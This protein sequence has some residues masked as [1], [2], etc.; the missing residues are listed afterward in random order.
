M[1][2]KE[3]KV[4]KILSYDVI[5]EKRKEENSE[6]FKN[7]FDDDIFLIKKHKKTKPK[8]IKFFII[9][10]VAIIIEIG[11]IIFILIY[12]N[13]TTKISC[14]IGEEEKCKTCKEASNECLACNPGYFIP[15]DEEKIK[16]KCQKC[17]V[18]NC[19]FCNGTKLSNMCYSCKYYLEPLIRKDKIISCDYTC[20]T[21]EKEKCAACSEENICSSCNDDY[22]LFKGKCFLDYSFR[23]TYHTMN[24][25]TVKLIGHPDIYRIIKMKIGE[26][27]LMNLSSNYTFPSAGN[28][29]VDILIDISQITSFVNFFKSVTSLISIS[30]YP[31]FYNEN[32]KDMSG[33]FSGCSSLVSIDMSNFQS[34]NIINIDEMF[35]YC[36]KLPF[37]NM[38]TFNTEN[39]KS[40][41]GLFKSCNSLVSIDFS[42]INT[43]NLVDM[44]HIF[45]NCKSLIS[46]NLS[47]FNTEKVTNMNGLFANCQ[48]L[49]S[50]DLS[51]FDTKNVVD[52]SWMFSY[53]NSLKVLDLSF[54]NTEK[55]INLNKM[56]SHC[57]NLTFINISNFNTQNVESMEFMFY[58]CK[59]LKSINLSSFITKKVRNMYSMLSSCSSLTS[60][61]I[62]NFYINSSVDISNM[63]SH[64]S[65]LTFI[66]ISSFHRR[67]ANFNMLNDLPD[68]GKIYVSNDLYNYTNEIL[69]NWEI[70]IP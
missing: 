34:Q 37:F 17:P 60:I 27:R 13:K 61:N 21:G 19:S 36:R 48:S 5:I 44:E 47:N 14:A 15:E 16:Y 68:K 39:V 63:F 12:S 9:I 55:V 30:F 23:A 33:F 65:N 45:V 29:T 20:E 67:T 58:E 59:S 3:E 66:D 69:P 52:M 26:E 46:L 22:T 28:H 51:N 2:N 62:S 53:C 25:E 24:N 6:I 18:A 57:R 70:F 35:N 7:D 10:L 42:N 54:F 43:N 49:T 11:L 38:S 64:C 56:F 40:M 41:K 31:S 1:D 8:I 4:S 32:I 50:I